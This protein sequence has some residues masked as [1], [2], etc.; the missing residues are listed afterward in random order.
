M[1]SIATAAHDYGFIPLTLSESVTQW[2]TNSRIY[3]PGSINAYTDNL[4]D[5]KLQQSILC[6]TNSEHSPYNPNQALNGSS[7]I[8]LAEPVRTNGSNYA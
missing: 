3:L 4:F 8:P 7:F 6:I 2:N 5:P 1:M